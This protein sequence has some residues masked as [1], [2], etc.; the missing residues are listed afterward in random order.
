LPW[1][2]HADL[3]LAAVARATP[4]FFAAAMLSPARE[5]EVL[6]T[7]QQLLAAPRHIGLHPGGI[8]LTPGPIA[9]FLP[10]ERAAKGVV[11]AQYDKDVLEGLGFVKIDLLGN[12]A[13]TIVRECVTSLQQQGIAV[14]DLHAIAEDDPATARL[15]RSGGT[16]GCFQVE[17]P[18][19]RTLLQQID[20]GTMDR[21]IQAVALV[22][23][24]PAAAGMK[25]AFV[26]RARGLAPVTAA[27]PLLAE[28]FA[29]TFGIMLYQ[30]DV[31][32]AAMAVAGMDGGA[33]DA[34]RRQLAKRGADRG[35]ELDAFVVAGLRHGLPRA[36]LEQVWEEMARFAA[37][38]FCKAHAVTYGRLAYRC[39]WLKARWPAA[40]LCAVLSN[41][42]GYFDPGVYVEEAKRLGVRF[43]PPCVQ[44]GGAE[45]ALDGPHAI[46]V[47]LRLV[48]GLSAATLQAILAAR[49]AGGAFRSLDDFLQRVRPQRDETENLICVGALDALGMTRRE[50]LWRLS[51]ASSPR[52][53]A[54]R[55]AAQAPGALFGDALAPREVRYPQLPD[56]DTAERTRH[57]LQLLGF[58]LGAHP[59]DVL[60]HGVGGGALASGGV[61]ERGVVPCGRI[62]A[63]VG[64]AVTV[65]GWVVARRGHRGEGEPMLFLTLEDGT[66]IV[67][68]TLFPKVYR[69]CGAEVQGRGPYFVRGVVEERMGGIGLRVTS[70]RRTVHAAS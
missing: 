34:L 55:A 13:L 64:Q 5:A 69:T 49:R 31:I 46:R 6:A 29:D 16:L 20:A 10:L 63:H 45:F 56:H 67:E 62:D 60:W 57:E 32:R 4:G 23:P 9:R 43:V 22:R 50:L 42:A 37:Y 52:V 24:G 41:D 54:Q 61:A 59:V 17:S 2:G 38:S 30:E 33:G 1:H 40:F 58:A 15:L 48:H 39:V 51:V 35:R 21:V 25:D 19:M 18:A 3:D 44:S 68:A 66:G 11:V 8:V 70:V 26:A 27:H 28:V 7:A 47:G 53:Q 36:V 14:P 12:R 65:H